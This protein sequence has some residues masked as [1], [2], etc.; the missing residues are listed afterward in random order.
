MFRRILVEDWQR[1]LSVSSLSTSS[2][3][4]ACH[5]PKLRNSNNFHSLPMTSP[6]PAANPSP[7]HSSPSSSSSTSSAAGEDVLRPHI[8][9]GIQE[10]D[11]RLPR[12]WLL[13][14]YGAIVFSVIYWAYY[15]AYE[16]GLDDERRLIVHMQENAEQAAKR[17]G[18]IDDTLIWKLSR[19]PQRI[20]AGKATFDTTCAA[21]HKPDLTGL[22]GPNLV[23]KEWI[24]GGKPMDSLKTIEEGILAKGMPAWS[25]ML[26]KEKITEL[27]AYIFS[28]HQPG[29]EVI[30][31]AG[32]TPP[33]VVPAP[34]P[35]P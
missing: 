13:T 6:D 3:F 24:H 15:H 5:G 25:A 19:E 21:C 18:I 8:Y 33:G 31:V 23:D 22:I 1:A 26:G 28:F 2:A 9:D 12:W 16:I 14:L 30:A 32:W 10:Y 34:A 20:A 35:T 11:K 17:S 27:T 7:S 4:A 29:E